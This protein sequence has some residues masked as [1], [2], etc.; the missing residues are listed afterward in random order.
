VI[1]L[2]TNVLSEFLRPRPSASV[3]AWLDEQPA[4]EV[5]MSAISRAEIELGLMLMPAGKRQAALSQA[6]W[7]M[8]DEDFHG[9]CLSFDED[10]ARHYARIVS[11]R[12]RVGRP[13]SVEHAQIAAIA[14]AH[15]APLATRNTTDFEMID[16]LGLA[17]PWADE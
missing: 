12:T 4:S 14:L 11:A 6:A 10:A 13:I 2:D 3:V 15:R 16:G 7:A 5:Y 8:F 17:N 1:L 9:R